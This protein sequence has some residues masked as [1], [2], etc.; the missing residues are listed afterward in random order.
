MSIINTHYITVPC[1]MM[2]HY[3]MFVLLTKSGF[4]L[5]L[6]KSVSAFKTP[7]NANGQT[8]ATAVM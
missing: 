5:K 6:L 1:T 2:Q 3:N 4:S 7:L 8:V